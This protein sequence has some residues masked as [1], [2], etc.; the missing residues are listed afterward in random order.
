MSYDVPIMLDQLRGKHD[1]L[2]VNLDDYD[3]ILGL[4]FLRKAKIV[5]VSYLI[6]VMIVSEGCPCFVPCCNE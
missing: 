5:L 3:I 4:D 6:G 2:V 1:L